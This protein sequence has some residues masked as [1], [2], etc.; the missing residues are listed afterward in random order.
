MNSSQTQQF[1]EPYLK[2]DLPEIKVGDTVKL[3]Q[4]IIVGADSKSGKKETE[5]IQIFEGLVIAKKHGKGIT[6]SMT[7][8]KIIDGVGVEK[9]VPLHSPNIAKIEV[10]G[11][12]KVR[13]AKLYYLRAIK[14]KKAKLKRKE[15][16]SLKQT[17]QPTEN[18]KKA[19]I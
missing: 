4:R 11:H 3:H 17:V 6:G 7:V 15:T 10:I 14:G 18:P 2:T 12:G 5:R 19:E 16:K 8:R 1:T 9:T 13:R